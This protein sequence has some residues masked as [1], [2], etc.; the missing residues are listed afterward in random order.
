MEKEDIEIGMELKVKSK[1]PTGKDYNSGSHWNKGLEGSAGKVFTVTEIDLS[2][3][4]QVVRLSNG[5]WYTLRH[6]CIPGEEL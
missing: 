1:L 2:G 5:I 4:K 3:H 6:L